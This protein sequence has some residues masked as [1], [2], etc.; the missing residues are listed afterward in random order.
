MTFAE[1][2]KALDKLTGQKVVSFKVLFQ[3]Y[4]IH[5]IALPPLTLTC[6]ELTICGY[7]C[8]N[9]LNVEKGRAKGAR[10]MLR[11]SL[12]TLLAHPFPSPMKLQI[13][14]RLCLFSSDHKTSYRSIS[15]MIRV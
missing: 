9:L 7:I 13:Q 14:R 12:R 3:Q 11:K 15:R 8:K 2:E 4:S 10:M 6:G 5:N 1:F